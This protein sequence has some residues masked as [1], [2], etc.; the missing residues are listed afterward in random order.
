MQLYTD[1]IGFGLKSVLGLGFVVKRVF[2][3]SIL[4]DLQEW[5]VGCSS[6]CIINSA[7]VFLLNNFIK[8]GEEAAFSN[9]GLYSTQS[10]L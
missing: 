8:G 2:R 9:F 6:T 7:L 4:T 3:H 5:E 10:F 1:L